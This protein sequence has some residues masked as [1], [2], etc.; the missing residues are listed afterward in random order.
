M[1]HCWT[2][3]K[4]RLLQR[5]LKTTINEIL[6]LD[7]M[8]FI[9]FF[10]YLL[11]HLYTSSHWWMNLTVVCKSSS[12]IKGITINSILIKDIAIWTNIAFL[13]LYFRR[14]K[15]KVSYCNWLRSSFRNL[16][17]GFFLSFNNSTRNKTTKTNPANFIFIEQLCISGI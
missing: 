1:I 17:F 7:G 14:G 3:L 8:C 16:F 5:K 10:C 12:L 2:S 4:K 15:F 6:T 11:N 13:Y 9:L